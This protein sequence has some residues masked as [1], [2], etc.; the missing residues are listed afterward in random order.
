[1]AD[2]F[3][4]DNDMDVSGINFDEDFGEQQAELKS[5]EKKAN[6][7]LKEYVACE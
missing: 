3:E 5:G 7:N 4:D 1:M 6:T 2:A